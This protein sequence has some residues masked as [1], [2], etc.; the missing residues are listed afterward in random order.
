MKIKQLSSTELFAE[1]LVDKKIPFI[2]NTNNGNQGLHTHNFIVNFN[3]IFVKLSSVHSYA[4]ISYL[5]TRLQVSELNN[6]DYLMFKI[7]GEFVF[8]KTLSNQDLFLKKRICRSSL[9]RRIKL[10]DKPLV[11]RIRMDSFIDRSL[12]IPQFKEELGIEEL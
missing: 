4:G 8:I 3:R 6:S 7:K 10:T 12:S 2:M 1:E 9:H 11:M 5:N